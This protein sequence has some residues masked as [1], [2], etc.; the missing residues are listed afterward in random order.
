MSDELIVKPDRKYVKH[1]VAVFYDEESG[2]YFDVPLK[3]KTEPQA[4]EEAGELDEN[5]YH[6]K[7][8]QVDRITRLRY[9]TSPYGHERHREERR[10]QLG[11][12]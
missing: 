6:G 9:Y 12:Q 2:N 11:Y 5:Q 8:V 10:K 1:Y 4:L 3:S 7:L